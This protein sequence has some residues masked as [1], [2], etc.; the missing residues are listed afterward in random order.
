MEILDSNWPKCLPPRRIISH[1]VKLY[2]SLQTGAGQLMF[3]DPAQ[4]LTRLHLPPNHPHFPFLGL[5]HAIMALAYRQFVSGDPDQFASNLLAICLIKRYWPMETDVHH[6]H[7][8]R[9]K[10]SIEQA[11]FDATHLFELI[12]ALN[13][14]CYYAYDVTQLV[15]AWVCSGLAV[16]FST[17]LGLN[18][19]DKSQAHL[20]GTQPRV[21]SLLREPCTLV[22]K[23]ERAATS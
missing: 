1:L 15:Q 17:P 22:E 18:L 14:Y 5:I 2:L 20:D 16:R 11:L 12:Q 3:I 19:L 8:D 4:F 21:R 9:A 7:A 6:Y 23:Y 10:R 13:I